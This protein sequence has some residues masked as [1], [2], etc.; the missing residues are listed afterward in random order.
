M[1]EVRL[2]A[3]KYFSLRHLN[4]FVD[5]CCHIII[6][7]L[8]ISVRFFGCP[9]LREHFSLCQSRFRFLS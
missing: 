8:T 3:F 1:E 2:L 9:L 4:V 7:I 6:N 5:L